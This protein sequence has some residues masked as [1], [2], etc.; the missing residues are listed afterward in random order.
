[1]T[2]RAIGLGLLFGCLLSA[3]AYFNDHVINQSWLAGSLMPTAV[4]G[5]LI[6]WLLVGNP[7]LVFV[8]RSMPA[9]RNADLTTAEC[10]VIVA[11]SLAACA[12]P[13]HGLF[14]QFT[15]AIAAPLVMNPVQPAW[16]A[17]ELMAYVPGVGAD[18]APAQVQDW[19][20]CARRLIASLQRPDTPALAAAWREMTPS[21]QQ[22][23]RDLAA[24]E[25]ATFDRT[26]FARSLNAAARRVG[27]N[28]GMGFTI[29]AVHEQLMRVCGDLIAVTP[30]G[31]GTLLASE[32][33]A[34]ALMRGG[35]ISFDPRQVPWPDV[36]PPL[37]L[38]G[39]LA[40][41]LG[42]A[43]LCLAII[44]HP[45]WS[46]HEL[47]P[48]PIAQ[49]AHE[50]CRR[51]TGSSWPSIVRQ[52]LFHVGM[53]G[54]LLLHIINGLHAWFPEVPSIRLSASFS[55]MSQI[56]PTAYAVPTS[57]AYFMPQLFPA[58]IGLGFMLTR[59]VSF[60]LAVAPMVWIIL[61]V[62]LLNRGQ[63]VS[64]YPHDP[65]PS[66]FLRLGAWL[67][68]TAMVV[69]FGR[70]YYAAV[71]C[72][73]MG[74]YRPLKDNV[75][76]SSAAIWSAWLALLL[77]IAAT[78][79]LSTAGVAWGWA[80]VL[81]LMCLLVNV[82]ISRLVAETGLF[83]IAAPFFAVTMILGLL[84][85][86]VLGPTAYIIL[87]V[88]SMMLAG[89]TREALMPLLVN[90]LR[91][92]DIDQGA[93]EPRS[94]ANRVAP[95]LA[96]MF[97]VGM[98]IASVATLTFQHQHGVNNKDRWANLAGPRTTFDKA[99]QEM[100]ELSAANA[101]GR[102]V[103]A[104]PLQRLQ[105]ARLDMGAASWLIAGAALTVALV[106]AR[107]RLPWWPL[108]WVVLA[109]TGM[110]SVGV[111]AVSFLIAWMLKTVVVSTWGASGY[112]RMLPMMIGLIAGDLLGAVL[113]MIV[114]ATYF[115]TTGLAPSD[116]RVFP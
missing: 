49:L 1:M 12:L 27:Q 72:R 93:H 16:Q 40:L 9:L 26:L 47:L 89:D 15:G 60:S 21:E 18:L 41:L 3:W 65:Q 29:Q 83:F 19:P 90:A 53:G 68:I 48:Y 96:L 105:F 114:G 61:G 58:I 28:A 76:V 84:G 86:E 42:G 107:I 25:L 55:A 109:T 100:S 36:L 23:W 52:R 81:V 79:L 112:R 54:V 101:D 5:G 22:H 110:W 108:H 10:L 59:P 51:P 44:V 56:F 24:Q 32:S 37:V 38:W 70:T 46:R 63:A 57:A 80:L 50:L 69:Y 78:A 73:A 8:G 99:A 87:A 74:I 20:E 111:F 104:S 39:G 11:V 92:V 35:S 6:I 77:I 103:A 34:V 7:L 33:A 62:V 88:G 106:L 31:R 66:V 75:R 43:G 116:Y 94:R 98:V 4:F 91:I 67:T 113:W 45:Q 64:W 13:G 95:W 115:A 82:V 2:Y 102:V 17:H 14:R 71:A 30:P 97:T 85:F